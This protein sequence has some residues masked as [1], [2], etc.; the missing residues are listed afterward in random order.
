[1]IQFCVIHVNKITSVL[2]LF[3]SSSFWS[4]ISIIY[5]LYILFFMLALEENVTISLFPDSLKKRNSMAIRLLLLLSYLH[6]FAFVVYQIPFFHEATVCI[7][8]FYLPI[9]RTI[10]LSKLVLVTYDGMPECYPA[11]G[12]MTP[13]TCNSPLSIRGMLPIIMI[14]ILLYFQKMICYSDAYNLVV[15]KIRSEQIKEQKR[16]DT[17]LEQVRS[18]YAS[19]QEG[20]ILVIPVIVVIEENRLWFVK[21]KEYLLQRYDKVKKTVIGIG[22]AVVDSS[23]DLPDPPVVE[24]QILSCYSA[25]IVI[26][27][28]DENASQEEKYVVR[29]R[30]DPPVVVMTFDDS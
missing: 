7:N 22:T 19:R 13:V 4:L 3:L 20:R 29:Y 10:G 15:K 9:V 28:T 8:D 26:V 16:R 23:L 6:L 2:V 21:L 11:Y 27:N 12:D 30:T 5:F 24:V 25:R 1:M 17:L 18:D 14:V